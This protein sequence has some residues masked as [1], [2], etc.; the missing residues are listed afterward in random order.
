MGYLDDEQLTK[1]SFDEDHWLRS[2]DCGHIDDD[3]FIFVT[4]RLKGLLNSDF[5]LIFLTVDDAFVDK[6]E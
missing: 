2:G 1:D 3:N 4:G 6:S 5:F